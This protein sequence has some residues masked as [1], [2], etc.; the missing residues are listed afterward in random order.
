MVVNENKL[1]FM[2][3]LKFVNF[4]ANFLGLYFEFLTLRKEIYVFLQILRV[5][6]VTI[7]CL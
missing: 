5:K 7:K 2:H 1:V 4:R 3:V 6:Y